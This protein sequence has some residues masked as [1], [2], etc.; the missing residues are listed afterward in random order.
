MNPI[1]LPPSKSKY[2]EKLD[3]LSFG[4]ATGFGEGKLRIQTSR[5]RG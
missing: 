2:E 1:I 3:S 4:M 5:R